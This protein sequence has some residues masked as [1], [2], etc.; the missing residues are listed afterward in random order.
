[1]AS[2]VSDFRPRYFSCKKIK[3]AGLK[4]ITLE[5]VQ[6]PDILLEMS[7]CKKSRV[8]AGFA[9]ET[10]DLLSNAKKKLVKK[11]LDI[12]VANKLD[13]AGSPFGAGKKDFYLVDK[14]GI[15]NK[16]SGISKEKLAKLLLDRIEKL[17]Y[18]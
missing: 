11:N 10:E 12:I 8:L 17:W 14:Y 9:L 13:Q 15:I 7:K 5:L 4:K 2:A 6:N 3:R 16:L 1:M 18:T